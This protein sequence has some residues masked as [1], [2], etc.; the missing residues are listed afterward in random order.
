MHLKSNALAKG[1]TL[2]A[3]LSEV[4]I[5]RAR[6]LSCR[7]GPWHGNP[8]KLKIPCKGSRRAATAPGARNAVEILFLRRRGATHSSAQRR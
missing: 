1:G 2:K 6:Q 4:A 3:I 8:M 5:T 7:P